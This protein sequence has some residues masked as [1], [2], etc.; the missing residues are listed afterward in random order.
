MDALLLSLLLN[1]ALDQGS[2]TQRVVARFGSRFAD[3]DV[4]PRGIVIGLAAMIAINAIVGA[5]LGAV[6]AALLTPDAR[7]LF[8]SMALAIGGTGLMIAALRPPPAETAGSMTGLRTL[9]HFAL[10]RAGE[11]AAF[12][13]AG[14]AAFTD[15]PLLTAGG[16]MIGGWAALA[17]SL[18]S[19]PAILR[20]WAM[21][22][23][24]LVG[25]LTILCAG[26]GCAA[27]AL[28]LL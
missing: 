14:V 1:L 10:R 17:P 28:G 12:A 22:S 27:S 20:H 19:G 24:Q 7:L 26:I 16:A 2:G 15:A 5:T 11:N 9:L 23:F 25:G 21:R 4:S 8:L 3:G 18:I 13:T 6:V